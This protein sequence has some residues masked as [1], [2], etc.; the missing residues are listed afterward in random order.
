MPGPL[1]PTERRRRRRGREAWG[2]AAGDLLDKMG[3]GQR[4]GGEGG[5]LRPAGRRREAWGLWDAGEAGR[6]SAEG[7][8][9]EM[10]RWHES[11]N[12][13]LTASLGLSYLFNR[14]PPPVLPWSR[15]L[16]RRVVSEPPVAGEGSMSPLPRPSRPHGAG[17]AGL[18]LRQIRAARGPP[19]L[20]AGPW[21]HQSGGNCGD[22]GALS[23][24][25]RAR[26]SGSPA[27]C[28]AS[29]LKPRLQA[30]ESLSLPHL[31]TASGT[32]PKSKTPFPLLCAP[33]RG[34][35]WNSHHGTLA[36]GF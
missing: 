4:R 13:G 10:D 24:N 20:P 16:T 34:V 15:G 12:P 9:N 23:P 21:G 25:C 35:G 29:S 2:A 6:A 27:P 14:R 3:V 26:G 18:A 31:R 5:G 28:G 7:D 33:N 30:L 32:R 11:G 19:G 22:C 17:E 36:L 8:N 1:G